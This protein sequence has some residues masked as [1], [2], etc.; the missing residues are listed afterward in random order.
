NFMKTKSLGNSNKKSSFK[1]PHVALAALLGFGAAGGWFY[2]ESHN[3]PTGVTSNSTNLYSENLFAQMSKLGQVSNVQPMAGELLAWTMLINGQPQVVF[4]T[5]DEKV[6]ITGNAFDTATMDSV[7]LPI[8]QKAQQG[9]APANS[10]GVAAPTGGNVAVDFAE[11]VGKWDK[12]VPPSISLLDK[13]K[14]AKEG[15]A[16]AVDTLYIVFDPRCSNCHDAYRATR[17]YVEKGFSIKW[18]PTTLLGKHEEGAKLAAA[19]LRDPKQLERAFSKD[20]NIVV[21]PT[22]EEKKALEENVQ[23]LTEATVQ[24]T[25]SQTIAVPTAFY[26]N[27]KTGEPKMTTGLSDE[28]ILEMIFGKI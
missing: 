5:K 9:G 12:E 4:T 17:K 22:P 13:L 27:K 11:I 2:Y 25:G 1:F 23:F 19:V 24:S 28:S 15:N 21:N 26:L 18:I 6:V 20:P 14:G 7:S 3:V 8:L 16:S 10:T